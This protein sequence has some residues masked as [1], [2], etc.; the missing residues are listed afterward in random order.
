M[1]SGWITWLIVTGAIGIFIW[2]WG[3]MLVRTGRRVGRVLQVWSFLGPVLPPLATLAVWLVVGD[4][5]P[6]TEAADEPWPYYV[7]TAAL[8]GFGSSWGR[9]SCSSS[10]SSG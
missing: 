1:V 8:T 5:A 7:G 3:W 9:R 2:L 6:S 4:A 10:S